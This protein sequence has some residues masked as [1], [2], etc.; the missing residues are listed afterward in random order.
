MS[1]EPRRG[2]LLRVAQWEMTL[3]PP[4]LTA[5][6]DTR[7]SATVLHPAP[8]TWGPSGGAALRSGARPRLCV[9]GTQA[10]PYNPERGRLEVLGSSGYVR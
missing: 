2:S 7:P 3:P 5:S 9:P 10:A 8:Q 1:Q 4:L 6:V